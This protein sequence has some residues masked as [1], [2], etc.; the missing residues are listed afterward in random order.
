MTVTAIAETRKVTFEEFMAISD[1][2]RHTEWI[3]GELVE[4][5]PVSRRHLDVADF[6][7]ALLRLFVRDN[8]LGIVA[9]EPFVMR[10]PDVPAAREP[11][12][13]F[14]STPNQ[15]R[16]LDTYLDG[17][18]NLV[19]EVVSLESRER[20]YSTK[21]FEYQMGGVDEYWVIDP[22]RDIATFY[23]L[24]S[25]G[26]YQEGNIAPDGYYYS[27]SVRGFRLNP[28]WLWQ[29]PLPDERTVLPL[30]RSSDV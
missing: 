13:F 18:A 14:V 3:R 19:I 16:M 29:E 21:Y 6:L 11:D 5:S 9:H 2:E 10:L 8:N 28:E 4:M 25:A 22:L 27:Q 30:S 7:H 17:P 24:D 12:V 23:L 15:H 20:D 1:A 26:K